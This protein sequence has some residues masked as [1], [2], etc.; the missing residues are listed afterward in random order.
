MFGYQCLCQW[1]A[2]RC[3]NVPIWVR[4]RFKPQEH[5][6][7][8]KSKIQV[9]HCWSSTVYICI[10]MSTC[11]PPL[12]FSALEM[13]LEINQSENRRSSFSKLAMNTL[14]NSN[15]PVKY[16][17]TGHLNSTDSISDGFY[18]VGKVC[19]CLRSSENYVTTRPSTI[20]FSL[21]LRL[22]PVRRF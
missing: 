1:S 13:L 12:S 11:V 4:H 6:W 7:K 5:C 22:K 19:I 8:E 3:R 10:W 20:V 21:S 14:L 17:L 9:W 18:D 16:G 15:L 2:S